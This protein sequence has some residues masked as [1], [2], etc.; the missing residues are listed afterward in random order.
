[1][2]DMLLLLAGFI[3][4][5]TGG[6]LLVRGSVRVAEYA[7]MSPLLI[8]LT[9]VGFGTSAPELV[10]SVQAA[11]AGSPGIAVGNIVGSNIANILLIL[12]VSAA[13]MPVPVNSSAI[14]RDGMIVLASAL[15]FNAI[16]LFL[17]LDRYV[18]GAL[19]FLL[20]L[21][22]W[23]AYR[24]E[25]AITA[26]NGHTAA[27]ERAEAVEQIHPDD[28][29]PK[30]RRRWSSFRI[31]LFTALLTALGGLLLVIA[32]GRLLVDAA[33]AIGAGLVF[34]VSLQTLFHRQARNVAGVV[35]IRHVGRRRR[36]RVIQKAIEDPHRS[37]DGMRI[38]AR[39]VAQQ[40]AAV[41][42]QPATSRS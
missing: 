12:G 36:G 37:F 26:A 3:V 39:G 7:G 19:L 23:Y 31:D 15:L 16:G 20:V 24:Q 2:T 27:F 29:A 6:E 18:G 13:I 22:L 9:L 25:R 40:S 10:T 8:G 14:R 33:V 34:Q 5:L 1:M 32:G 21:Y 4:L 35:E 41:R 30:T 11:L 28:T 17:P 38:L 42:E